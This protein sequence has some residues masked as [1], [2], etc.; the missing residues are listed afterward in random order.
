[1]SA[2]CTASGVS[3][4]EP[5][6]HPHGEAGGGPR[7]CTSYVG[8]EAVRRFL[9]VLAVVAAFP[10]GCGGGDAAREPVTLALDFQPNPAHAGIY[11][12]LHKDIDADY[13]IDLE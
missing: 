12:A 2:Q 10:L 8:F 4:H 1:M 5:T 7:S 3:P 13:G 11:A 9:F 6:G